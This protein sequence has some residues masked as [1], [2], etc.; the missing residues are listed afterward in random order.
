MGDDAIS[1]RKR[2]K[3]FIDEGVNIMRSFDILCENEE[4]WTLRTPQADQPR[5]LK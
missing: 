2:R 4:E 1:V 3:K 5:K